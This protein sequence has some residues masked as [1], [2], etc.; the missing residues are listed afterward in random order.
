[1]KSFWPAVP[2]F[3]AQEDGVRI[4][5]DVVLTACEALKKKTASTS[6]HLPLFRPKLQSRTC[7]SEYSEFTH[8]KRGSCTRLRWLMLIH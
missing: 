2:T 6:H 1:M 4:D 3:G 5:S 7:M 8:C